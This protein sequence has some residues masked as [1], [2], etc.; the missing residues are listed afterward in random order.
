MFRKPP[1]LLAALLATASIAAAQ[2]APAPKV[3]EF[4]RY[5]G[6]SQPVYDGWVRSSRYVTVRDGTRLAMDIFRPSLKGKVAGEKLPVVWTHNRYRRA[7]MEEG[8]TYTILDSYEWL[9]EV[10][11]HGYVV[12]AVDVRGSGASFGTFTGMFNLKETQDAYDITEWFAAQAWSNGNVGMYGGSYLGITQYMAAGQKPPHLKAIFPQVA[13]SDLYDLLWHGGIF[14]GP[15]IESWSKLVRQLDVD[16]PALPVNEDKDGSLLKAAIQQHRANRDAAKLYAALPYRDSADP[17]TGV[18][19]WRDWTPITYLKQIRESKV[20]VYHQAGWYD[21]YVR[22]QTILFRN[23]DN[24]QKLTIG[25]WTHTESD[26][27]SAAEHLRW[28]DRWLKGIDNGVMDDAPVHYYV[29]GA[30]EAKAWRSA[31][32]WPLPNERRTAYWFGPRRSLGTVAPKAAPKDKARDEMTVDYSAA[33]SP[34]PRWSLERKFPE[35]SAHDAKGLAYT[36]PPLAAAVEVT[37]HPV[38]HLWVSSSVPDADLFVYLEE[39]DGKGASR[40]VTEGMLRASDRATAD[41]GYD[42]AGLP[43]HRGNRADRAD[44]APGQPVE[45][46]FDLYPTSTLFAAGHRIRVTVTGADKANAVTPKRNPPPRITLYREAGKP[47]YV[48]LPVIP[49]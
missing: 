39:V 3:S 38:V 47:S 32:T 11:R 9:P 22:D 41:P 44:L 42:T 20:A 4:N 26:F 17:Q 31:K 34:D 40:Y 23:L 8:K 25:P 5:S 49:D 35:L 15:F 27:D 36:T 18:Q 45:L 6:Y 7:V 43:Y 12:A 29:M 14:H 24:P 10:V 21:R 1:L 13:V 33:V 28:W 37:G 19:V 2:T 48:E 30:P 16:H 46:V